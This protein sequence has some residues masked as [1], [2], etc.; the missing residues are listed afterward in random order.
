MIIAMVICFL[1]ML[2]E[3][4]GGVIAHS[5]ALLTD[6]AHLLS[7]V[8]SF[9]VVIFTG[10]LAMRRSQPHHTFGYHR[11]PVFQC[12]FLRPEMPMST[13]LKHTRFYGVR[14]RIVIRRHTFIRTCLL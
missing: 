12:Q 14:F 5:L 2:G 10:W 6:A 13:I 7:D 4:A 8:A 11:K 3:I 1:F 9:A